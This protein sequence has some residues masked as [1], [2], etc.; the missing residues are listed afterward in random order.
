M[1]GRTIARVTA[2]A[3]SLGAGA[4]LTLT[5]TAT[6][7]P[8]PTPVEKGLTALA[9]R[10]EGDK[11]VTAGVGALREYTNLVDVAKLRDINGSFAPFAYP[12]PTF[13]CGVNGLVTTII[14]AGTANGPS[15]NIG[16]NSAPGTLMFHA[17]PAHSGV[18]LSSGLVVAWVNINN[19]AS[20]IDMLDERTELGTPAL[21][22]TVNSGPGT[23]LASMWGTIDYPGARCV[24]M[25]T[26]G[27]FSVAEQPVQ[28]PPPAESPTPAPAPAPAES[29]NGESGEAAVAPPAPEAA[30]APAPAPAATT[31]PAKPQVP[32]G[33]QVQGGR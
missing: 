23:V 3:A 26:V 27:T 8:A 21:A 12:A 28:L 7:D 10:A 19:G 13:G 11:A 29:G 18:P 2:A 25:P 31:A 14:G 22:K 32:A 5:A 24:M 4:V 9:D 17:T 20:G 15:A 6:A 30:P 1:N 16:V 33:T